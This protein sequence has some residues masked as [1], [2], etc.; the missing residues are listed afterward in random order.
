LTSV[1]RAE[2]TGLPDHSIDLYLA[3]QCWHW[4]D[5]P[6][7]ALEAIRI[8]RPGGLIVCASYDYLPHRSDLARATEDLLLK[9]NPSWPMAG[10]HGVH[11][12][13]LNDLPNAGFR[14]VEQFSYEHSQPFTH[15]QWRGRMRTCNGVGAS[16]D[17]PRV[18]AFDAD[19]ASLLSD[20]FPSEPILVPHRVWAVTARR[21]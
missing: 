16:L 15:E 20:R 10:G 3:L 9:H 2:A 21:P 12:N 6:R 13:P 7:A 5:R 8:L 1:A 11:I 14:S 19:L 18:A 4:F 17:A